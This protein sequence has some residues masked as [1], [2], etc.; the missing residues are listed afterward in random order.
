MESHRAGFYPGRM[1]EMTIRRVTPARSLG[2][3]LTIVALLCSGC[4]RGPR[5]ADP[6]SFGELDS[7][8]AALL[9]ELTAAVHDGRSDAGSW[10]R[11][12]MGLEA[13]GLLVQAAENY[14][15]AVRLDGDE[16]RW[17]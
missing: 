12:A 4:E 1:L 3:A 11:L 2:A 16:P 7:A 8:V 13:N 5:P 15:V 9:N 6:A 10:G 14:E 17:R